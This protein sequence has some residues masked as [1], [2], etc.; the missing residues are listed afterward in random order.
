MWYASNERLLGEYGDRVARREAEW[1]ARWW[2]PIINAEHL[3]MRDRVG[4][5]DLSAFAIFDVTGPGAVGYLEGLVVS[6]VEVPVGRVI[7]TPLLQ[8][9]RGHRGRPDDHAA[10]AR[11]LPR[12]HGRR[13][14]HA[15]QEVVHRPPARGRLRDPHRRHERLDDGRHLGPAGARRRRLDHDRRRVQRGLPL[16][17]LPGHRPGS[18][19]R[20]GVADLVRRRARLGALRA[21]GGGPAALGPAGRGWVRRTG[22]CRSGSASTRR[23]RGWR[24]ATAPTATSSSSTSTS[25]R[26]AWRGRE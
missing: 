19:A 15:R 24:R 4:M 12:R 7:Y 25:S 18:G 9:G 3:A 23:R 11:P 10:R 16:R 6:P 17:D 26:R 1:D 14:G 21:D 13:H 8:R 5:V 20:P 2:S 22:S